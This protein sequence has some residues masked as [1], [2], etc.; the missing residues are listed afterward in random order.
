MVDMPE[1]SRVKI[2]NKEPASLEKELI[3]HRD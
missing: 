1:M 3:L 2:I